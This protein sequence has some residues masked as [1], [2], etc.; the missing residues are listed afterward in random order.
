MIFLKKLIKLC[1]L[2]NAHI[3]SIIKKIKIQNNIPTYLKV[4]IFIIVYTYI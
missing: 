3:F 1:N 2:S 4:D